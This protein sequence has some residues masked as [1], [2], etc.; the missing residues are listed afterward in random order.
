MVTVVVCTYNQEQWIRQTLDSIL[1][2]RTTYPYEIIIGED[3]GT[4]GTRAIC[5]EYAAK[6]EN[7]IMAP[8]DHNLGLV[9]NWANCIKH[10]IGKYIMVC[11]GD[12]YWH[13]PDKIQLQVDFMEAHPECVLC[14]T[15]LDVLNVKTNKLT[16]NAKNRTGKQPPEGR[17]QKEILSGRDFVSAVT[18]CWRRDAFEKYVPVEKFIELQFPR[19]DWP[20]LLILSSYGD[21]RYLPISTATYR[22]GHESISNMLNYERIK[23][24]FQKDKVML[25]YIYSLFPEWGPFADGPYFDTYVY[26]CLLNAAYQNNDYKAAKEFAKKDP[27][28]GMAA[29]A[30]FS[31]SSFQLYRYY[32][33]WKSLLVSQ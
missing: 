2:Q 26:H 19:E 17:I 1:A 31:W 18:M 10:G 32:H 16:S 21:I 6:Y 4:D 9:A 28:K 15:D 13:N 3:W 24:R 30:T 23:Q 33:Q 27:K 12:D 7:V 11:A 25:E 14:H 22:V 8:S 5:E 29:K 20:M